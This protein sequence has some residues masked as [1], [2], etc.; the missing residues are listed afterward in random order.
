[1][2]QYS[3]DTSTFQ[4]RFERIPLDSDRGAWTF[5]IDGEPIRLFGSFAEARS[6]AKLY[7]RMHDHAGESIELNNHGAIGRVYENL[8]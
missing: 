6:L 1:M 2:T 8:S 7:A 3:I 5:I 4:A